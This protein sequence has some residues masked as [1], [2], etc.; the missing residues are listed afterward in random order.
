[1]ARAAIYAALHAPRM[2]I[3][4]CHAAWHTVHCCCYMAYSNNRRVV[5]I[6][7][8]K[9]TYETT[10]HI[11]TRGYAMFA[12]IFCHYQLSSF[13]DDVDAITPLLSFLVDTPSTPFTTVARLTDILPSPSVL[14]AFMPRRLRFFFFFYIC[15]CFDAFFS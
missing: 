10:T 15:L 11:T 8:I 13:E 3:V 7:T 12:I 1:M 2:P 5:S 14:P 6:W 9:T 4:F